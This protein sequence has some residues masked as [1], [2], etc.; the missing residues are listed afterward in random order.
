[1][2]QGPALAEAFAV[3]AVGGE[4]WR[5][6]EGYVSE[7]PSES[8]VNI[9]DTEDESLQPETQESTESLMSH[10]ILNMLKT[11]QESTISCILT[12][13]IHIR[14]TSHTRPLCS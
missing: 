10:Q 13:A 5:L 7:G 4:K 6:R 3:D 8:S 2:D 14:I 9:E 1:M 12:A 11:L